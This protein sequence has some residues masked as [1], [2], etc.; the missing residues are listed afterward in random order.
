MSVL[1]GSEIESGDRGVLLL[2]IL[3]VILCWFPFLDVGL[4]LQ[5]GFAESLSN[6]QNW[7]ATRLRTLWSVDAWA[8]STLQNSPRRGSNLPPD[9][10]RG[11]HL[12][13]SELGVGWLFYSVMRFR[14]GE[15]CRRRRV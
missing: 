8:K 5:I 10:N 14:T 2:L 3:S 11:I 4:A 13:S 9:H 6:C 15:D 1:P 7:N 12:P